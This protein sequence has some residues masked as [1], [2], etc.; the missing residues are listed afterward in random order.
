MKYLFFLFSI[1]L[2]GLL[3]GCASPESTTSGALGS[4]P[5]VSQGGLDLSRTN[6]VKNTPSRI[7]ADSTKLPVSSSE[8]VPATGKGLLTDLPAGK[9]S[10]KG[11]VFVPGGPMMMGSEQGLPREQPEHPVEIRGFFMDQGPVTVAQFRKFVEA[12]GY[13]TQAEGFGDAVV[14]D[15]EQREWYL[16]KTAYWAYPLGTDQPPAEDTHPVTQ[17]SW[18]DATAYCQW[19]GKRLPTEAEWEHA[20]RNGRNSRSMYSWGQE[21]RD[22]GGKG[23]YKANIWQGI[24][25]AQNTGEDGYLFTS[26][27][28]LFNQNELG[29]QDMS[30]NVWEWCMD[31]YRSY[32][33]GNPDLAPL[34][35]QEPE[36]VMRGG[37]FMCD[38]SYCWGYRVSGRSGSSPETGLFHTGFRCVQDIN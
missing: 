27:V 36:K 7:P 16:K 5:A 6:A 32:D 23:R 11:M 35:T 15:L 28:G 21:V 22:N 1:S 25:P 26:P 38:P 4:A 2:I 12:T 17:V 29:L 14:F 9:S 31:W 19:A 33:P 24:F 8:A 30:G 37:S 3:G 20:A 10:P 18:H 13:Q 34:Q